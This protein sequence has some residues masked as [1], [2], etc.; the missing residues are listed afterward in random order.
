MDSCLRRNEEYFVRAAHTGNSE[1]QVPAQIILQQAGYESFV[2][3]LF[4]PEDNK[5]FAVEPK[6]DK[7]N[8]ITN[9]N[10]CMEVY[11]NPANS[12]LWVEYLT[13]PDNTPQAVTIYTLDG[14][15]VYSKP[16]NKNYGIL[17]LDVSALQQGNYIV[18]IGN[19]SKQ[20]TIVK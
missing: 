18:K 6:E 13:L 4:L 1:V 12:E 16:V 5:S 9:I 19:Y 7:H 20:I 15:Q 11:P 14:K 8:T 17:Q 2:S 3:P 10:N